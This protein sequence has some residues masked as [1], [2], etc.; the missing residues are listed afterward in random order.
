M[1]SLSILSQKEVNKFN[2]LPKFNLQQ[3][4]YFFSLPK[5]LRNKIDRFENNNNKIIFILL[6]GYFKA[7]NKFF[8]IGKIY[9]STQD[10][11]LI[12][13]LYNFQKQN[14]SHITDRRVQQ[15]QQEIKAY[16]QIVNYSIQ[17][18]K[19]IQ[20]EATNQANN[21]IHRKKIFYSLVELSKKLK[22]EIPS[23]TELSRIITVAINTQKK[24]ILKKLQALRNDDRLNILDEFLLK[25]DNYKNR[26][27]LMLYKKL[28]HST[29]KSKMLL[30]LS[31]FNTIKSKYHILKGIID[32]VGLTPK[33][34]EYHAK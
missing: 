26:Y 24:D 2:S 3:Q 22:I 33:I 27:R 23:Y 6:Y 4:R 30:S 16:F 31:K 12:S 9:D 10:I 17:L 14:I 11:K 15:Y 25:D 1:T 7:S 29:T 19:N 28:E 5:I 18:Q 13:T 21:F 34:A 8:K 32:N 20:K